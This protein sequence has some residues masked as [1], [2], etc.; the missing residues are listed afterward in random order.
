MPSKSDKVRKQCGEKG[1][2]KTLARSVKKDGAP[3][4]GASK[5]VQKRKRVT[6]ADIA[7]RAGVS[8]AAVSLTLAGR[9]D[10]PLA[11]ATRERIKQCARELGYVTNRLADG[12]FRGRS[13]L[14]GI[15]IMADSYRPFLSC[16]AGIHEALAQADCFPLL[17][18]GHWMEGYRASRFSDGQEHSELADLFRLLGYQ[19]DGIIYFSLSAHQT[20]AAA[21]A[22]ELARRK[23]PMVIL[24][25]V[26]TSG[27]TIDIV[28]GDNQ[29]TGR[30][31]ADHLLSVGC[32]SFIFVKPARFH[33][34]DDAIHS[35]FAAKLTAAGHSCTECTLD[36]EEPG[37]LRALLSRQV[38]P[39]A[40]IFCTRDDIAALV[41]QTV[42]T[43]GWRVPHDVAVVTMGQAQMPES[44]FNAPPITIAERHSFKAGKAAVKLLLQRIEGFSGQP[45]CILIPPF[46]RSAH[47]VTIQGSLAGVFR[48]DCTG[49]AASPL[50]ETRLGSV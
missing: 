35:S 48:S 33:P 16:I 31:V 34:L 10:V 49:F 32:T 46:A 28:G 42:L 12:F 22:K 39:P 25:G 27:G 36:I 11:E 7:H 40:G 41:L 2:R 29:Q 20:H 21:C 15:L 44:R 17:M 38:R 14:I 8:I 30:M 1:E 24:G 6:L 4:S 9:L 18:S 47:V 5:P 19:V 3:A 37:D 13:K 45:K 23:I 26:D 43:L 50:K